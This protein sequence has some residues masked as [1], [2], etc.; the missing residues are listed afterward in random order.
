M[1]HVVEIIFDRK[2][3]AYQAF[4]L[5]FSQGFM[6]DYDG[7]ESSSLIRKFNGCDSQIDSFI[8]YFRELTLIVV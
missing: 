7:W 5:V 4:K 1:L 2:L 3:G 6:S 8:C